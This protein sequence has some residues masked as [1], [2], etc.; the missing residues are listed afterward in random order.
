MLFLFKKKEL[1]VDCFTADPYVYEYCKIMPATRYFPE[2]FKQLPYTTKPDNTSKTYPSIKNC[3][4]FKTLYKKSFVLPFWTT[5]NVRVGKREDSKFEW[6]CVSHLKIEHHHEKQFDG[7]L[8]DQKIGH[9]KFVSPWFLKSK[10]GFNFHWS[11]PFWNN[12]KINDYTVIPGILDFKYQH[13]TNINILFEFKEKERTLIIEPGT[14]LVMLTPLV[15]DDVTVKLVHHQITEL[16]ENKFHNNLRFSPVTNW[17][18]SKYENL[19]KKKKIN[20]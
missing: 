12:Q 13:A 10:N 11:E 20:K 6:E 14:P 8:P 1:I 5:I 4:G 3:D 19:Y 18:P 15:N 9:L 7:F 2:W 17:L 16:E